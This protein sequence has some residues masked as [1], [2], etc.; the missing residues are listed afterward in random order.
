M[1][2]PDTMIPYVIGPAQVVILRMGSTSE[3]PL[4]I[5]D[6]EEAGVCQ[7]RDDGSVQ[8]TGG[9]FLADVESIMDGG[10]A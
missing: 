4:T 5:V 8:A 7:F 1:A 3:S 10:T 6:S 9:L 2:F